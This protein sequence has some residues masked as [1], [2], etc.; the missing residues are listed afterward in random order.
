[1]LALFMPR[2]SR[3]PGGVSVVEVPSPPA[4]LSLPDLDKYMFG[5]VYMLIPRWV[6]MEWHVGVASIC[7][8]HGDGGIDG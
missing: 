5:L 8:V 4:L 7:G 2:D 1:M 3:L 6:K